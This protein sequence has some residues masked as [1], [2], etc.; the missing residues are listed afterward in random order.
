M[1]VLWQEGGPQL[2]EED[3]FWLTERLT[4]VADA[5]CDG[6]VVSVLEGGYNPQVL[7]RCVAAHVRAL[8]GVKPKAA[9]GLAAS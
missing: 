8:V 3:F 7:R 6:K 4:E 9:S 5:A 2:N 1:D